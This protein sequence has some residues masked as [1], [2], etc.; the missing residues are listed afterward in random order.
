MRGTVRA[1]LLKEEINQARRA[2][3]Q[4]REALTAEA[5][6]PRGR[7][8][9]A[10][11]Q[12]GR[13]AEQQAVAGLAAVAPEAAGAGAVGGRGGVDRAPRALKR[14]DSPLKSRPRSRIS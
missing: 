14:R 7:G 13:E 11:D 8:A 3:A 1:A 9:A 4:V 2:R 5:R 12:E 10:D 6:A